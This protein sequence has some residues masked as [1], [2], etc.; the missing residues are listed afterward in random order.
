[1]IREVAFLFILAEQEMLLAIFGQGQHN[2]G[3][4]AK[5]V[6]MPEGGR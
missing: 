1:V 4:S 2:D 6:R 5:Q 3:T